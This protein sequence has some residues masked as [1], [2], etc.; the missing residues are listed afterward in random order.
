[1]ETE[2]GTVVA[3]GSPWTFF[4]PLPLRIPLLGRS[5][6]QVLHPFPWAKVQIINTPRKK[7]TPAYPLDGNMTWPP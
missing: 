5:F 3:W 4:S 2:E 1:M 7:T 6:Y